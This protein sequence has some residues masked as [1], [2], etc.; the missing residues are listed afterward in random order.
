MLPN[1]D[2]ANFVDVLSLTRQ[3]VAIDSQNPGAGESE[4]ADFVVDW[5]AQR[6]ISA[7]R[8]EL[9]KGRP[10]VIATVTHSAGPHLGLTGH[11]DTK[12][13]GDAV[14]EWKTD[15][16]NLSIQEGVAYGLGTSDMKG[17]VAAMLLALKDF[18]DN[19]TRGA[20]SLILTADEEQGSAAGAQALI[21]S[22]ALPEVDALII[23]EPSG[24]DDPWE[25][26]HLVSRGICCFTV[27]LRTTQGHSGLSQRLGRNAMLVAADV[28]RAFENFHPPI[29]VPGKTPCA[30]TVNPGMMIQGGVCFGVWPGRAEVAVEIRTV[31]GME[32]HEVASAVEQTVS[33]AVGDQATATVRYEEGSLGWMPATE[34]DPEHPLVAAAHRAATEVLGH[35]IPDSAYPGGTDAGYFMGEHGIPTV[36]SLGPGWLSVAHG[37]NEKVGVNQLD[38]ALHLYR[39]LIRQYCELT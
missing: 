19:G 1:L 6:R 7:Q 23:G 35:D 27:D 24:I 5:L 37:A 3:L 28:L 29:A 25:A 22:H 9:V 31:P 33:H 21:N 20:V 10:N 16:F 11:L 12:P 26:L 32:R 39:A 17:A 14:E 30:P 15:P 4:I 8:V 2:G 13:I 36:V 38:E 18:A 34:I